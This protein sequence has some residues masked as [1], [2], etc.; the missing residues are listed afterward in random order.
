M[1]I[2][3]SHFVNR[4]A[5][6]E[7]LFFQGNH[8]LESGLGLVLPIE[9]Q[10]IAGPTPNGPVVKPAIAVVHAPECNAGNFVFVLQ[11]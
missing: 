11:E 1:R 4:K 7:K 8:F 2:G 10:R 9:Q 6:S 3:K 5:V